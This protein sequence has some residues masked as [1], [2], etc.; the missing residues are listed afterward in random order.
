MFV[1]L[2]PDDLVRTGARVVLIGPVVA[3]HGLA[4][5]PRVVVRQQSQKLLK[6]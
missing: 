3:L 4:A 6:N 1:D 2:N 5:A